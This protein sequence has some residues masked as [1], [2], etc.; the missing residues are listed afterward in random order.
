MVVYR[1]IAP[2]TFDSAIIAAIRK[3]DVHAIVFAS[4]SA[5]HN[6][7]NEIGVKEFADISSKVAIAA[8]GSTTASAVRDAGARCEVEAGDASDVRLVAA[9]EK[10]FEKP[11]PSHRPEASRA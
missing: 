11:L 1:T 2:A 5:F 6:L 7:S 10:H 4:P 9:L 8:I 3:A